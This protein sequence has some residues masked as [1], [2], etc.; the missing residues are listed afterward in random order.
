MKTLRYF[1]VAALA[2]VSFNVMAD[3][4]DELT[5]TTLSIPSAE[6]A[7]YAVFTANGTSGAAYS[8][9]AYGKQNYIQIRSNN[10]NSGI[11]VTTTPNLYVKSITV[12]YNAEKT[13]DKAGEINVFGKN[14]AYTA[15]S[16]LYADGT[17]GTPVGQITSTSTTVEFK[18]AFK[19]F[20]LRSTNG[21]RYIDK[22]TVVWTETAPSGEVTHI[23]N[24]PETAYSIA[25]AF[26]IINAGE[27][28]QETVYVKGKI[29]KIDSYNSTYK[30]ITYW[31][32]DAG[33]TE[34]K[35]LECYSGKGLNGADFNAKE[36]I[37]VGASV[38]V[39]GTLAKYQPK[40]GDPIYEFNS[41]NQ[42]YSYDA[43]GAGIEAV[44]AQ[45]T[46]FEGK[47]YNIAGQQV[48]E[49]YKGLVIMNGKK[50]ILK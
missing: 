5:A 2:M 13:G 16:D 20:G 4:T 12:V 37:A 43:S 34:E 36:D 17:K 45:N 26:D 30:S 46:K 47:V 48:T 14:D 25:D 15:P 10:N 8:A 18:E 6:T 32:S 38:I 40:E 39:K 1:F 41:G 33:T 35:M 9:Q 42:L 21:T 11:V 44:K 27:A 3:T 49:S 23:E 28:L 19:F 31:I 50:M 22:V 24:T 29:C 7:A